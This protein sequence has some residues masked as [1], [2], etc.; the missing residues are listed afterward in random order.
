MFYRT[1]FIIVAIC[2]FLAELSNIF[3]DY[4]KSTNNRTVYCKRSHALLTALFCA[5]AL[6]I[7]WSMY[8]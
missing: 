3:V 8:P 1:I 7:L 6:A 2:E 5:V 4:L